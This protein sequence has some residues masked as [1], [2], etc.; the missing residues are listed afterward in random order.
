[1]AMIAMYRL[2]TLH[3]AGGRMPNRSTTNDSTK[4][5]TAWKKRERRTFIGSFQRE[6]ERDEIGVLLGGKRLPESG[7]HHPRR[8][9]GHGTH[10]LG[11]EDLLHD[12]VG[13]LD[14]GDLR[15]VGADRRARDVA[16]LVTGQAAAL[17]HEYG[18]AHLGIAG[19]R[20]RG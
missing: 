17:G 12:V 13:G 18:L 8:E 16:G 7:R 11:I 20:N 14:L 10:A 5:T 15:Q 9:A 2:S 4:M 1:M 19:Q 3:G 6:E